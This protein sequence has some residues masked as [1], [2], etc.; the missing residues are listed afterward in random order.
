MSDRIKITEV[1]DFKSAQADNDVSGF[2][3][4][5]VGGG[6]GQDIIDQNS[7]L[8]G[9]EVHFLASPG[10]QGPDFHAPTTDHVSGVFGEVFLADQQ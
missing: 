2:D 4:L 5:L 10:D 8:A 9:W 6:S 1:V 7:Q 3:V